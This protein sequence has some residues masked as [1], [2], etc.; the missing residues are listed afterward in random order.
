MLSTRWNRSLEG[1]P[2]HILIFIQVFEPGTSS[3][4][5]KNALRLIGGNSR[6][7]GSRGG[8]QG[9]PLNGQKNAFFDN[10][11]ATKLKKKIAPPL[12]EQAGSAY[13]LTKYFVFLQIK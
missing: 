3:V 6:I 7:V 1:G 8:G 11:S 9:A 10:K 2:L 12:T 13:K 5:L 4:G